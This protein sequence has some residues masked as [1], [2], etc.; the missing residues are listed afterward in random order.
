MIQAVSFLVEGD[1]V[2]GNLHLPNGKAKVP[3]VVVAGPMTSVKEQVTGVYARA[4]ACR[5]IAALA[6]DHRGF[7]ESGGTPRQFEDWRRKVRD[8]SEALKWLGTAHHHIDPNRLGAAGIC[9]GCGYVA[10]LAKSDRRVKSLGLVAGYYRDPEAI[11][12]GDPTGFDARLAQGVAARE[13]YE[14]T[15]EVATIPAAALHGDAAMQTQDTYDYYTRRAAVPNYIN[16][17]AIMSREVFLPFDVLSTASALTM[18]VTMV[19]SKTALSPAWAQQF[20]NQLNGPKSLH[21]VASR[22]QTD[23]YDDPALVGKCADLIA[24]NFA[25]TI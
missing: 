23:F 12:T 24:Q 18:P 17:F 1:R 6:I 21:F 11:R 15:G 8:L 9:L 3:A 25:A 16:A 7:G 22:G 19:H 14:T 13:L 4:L 20:Y 10:A 2:V 5:G